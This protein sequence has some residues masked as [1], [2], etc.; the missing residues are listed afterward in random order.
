MSKVEFEDSIGIIDEEI[1]KRKAKW[2]LKILNW[3][4]YEDVSQILRIHIFKKW[5]L[6]EP[7]K[8]LQPWLNRIISNQ[9]KNL[10]RNHYGNYVKPCSKCAAAEDDDSCRVYGKQ[11]ATCPLYAHWVKNKKRAYESKLPVPIDLHLNEVRQRESRDIDFERA[12]EQICVKI[13]PLLKPIERRA[14][15]YLYID[16]LSEEETAK[17]LGYKT[18]DKTRSPGY[19]QIRI[20]SKSIIAKA[21]KLIFDQEISW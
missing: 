3:M 10:I 1:L 5:H 15:K 16:N 4:D 6:Y 7:S 20:I 17:K 14:F 13:M 19:K 2:N 12:L 21:K 11:D 8:S 18:G 9:L